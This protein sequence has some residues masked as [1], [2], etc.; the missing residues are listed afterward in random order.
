MILL[1]YVNRVV[2]WCQS[3]DIPRLQ[4]IRDRGASAVEYALLV[5]AVVAVV[6]AF[7]FVM[8][9]RSRTLIQNACN[10]LVPGSC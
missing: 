9:N 1:E 4:D 6:A 3:R 5:G 10:A 8:G 7:V 2:A